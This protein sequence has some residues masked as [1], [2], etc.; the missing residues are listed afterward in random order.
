MRW[1]ETRSGFGWD[2][3]SPSFSRRD[4][5]LPGGI[6]VLRWGGLRV[7]GQLRGAAA[8]REIVGE[9]VRDG[10]V[11]GSLPPPCGEGYRRGGRGLREW[12]AGRYRREA[13]CILALLLWR[14]KVLGFH[15][16]IQQFINF[17]NKYIFWGI[18]YVKKIQYLL[19]M[20]ASSVD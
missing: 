10:E 6:L 15:I 8:G 7:K 11:G 12:G 13:K 1:R 4:D 2:L 9:M 20:S 3:P 18:N 19:A 5:L 16:Y 17:P 14:E